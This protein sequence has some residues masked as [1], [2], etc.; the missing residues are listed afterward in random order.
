[1]DPLDTIANRDGL[2]DRVESSAG[3]ILREIHDRIEEVLAFRAPDYTV[4]SG[5]LYEIVTLL[6]VA[7]IPSPTMHRERIEQLSVEAAG[8]LARFAARTHG[9]PIRTT[10]DPG[11]RRPTLPRTS[12]GQ[13][14]DAGRRARESRP[15]RDPGADRDPDQSRSTPREMAEALWGNGPQ[16]HLA[17]SYHCFGGAP[18]DQGERRF[19]CTGRRGPHRHRVFDFVTG[20]LVVRLDETRSTGGKSSAGSRRIRI[21]PRPSSA[22]ASGRSAS[23]PSQPVDAGTRHRR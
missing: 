11:R 15:V 20:R 10:G 5:A 1:M 12:R 4:L 8:L 19:Y 22:G 17:I 3:Y 6:D 13:P 2:I 18:L 7:R 16:T 21:S 23:A 9:S 14:R